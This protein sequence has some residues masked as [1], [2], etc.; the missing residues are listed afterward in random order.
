MLHPDPS[1]FHEGHYDRVVVD[2]CINDWQDQDG[3]SVVRIFS[4]GETAGGLAPEERV[5]LDALLDARYSLLRVDETWHGAGVRAHDAF[6]RAEVA[7]LDEDLADCEAGEWF[8]ARLVS[9]RG[10]WCMT[11]GAATV[12]GHVAGDKTPRE[13]AATLEGIEGRGAPASI[14]AIALA[15]FGLRLQAERMHARIAAEIEGWADAPPPAALAPRR[16]G[17]NQPCPC[18]SG[19][20]YKRCCGM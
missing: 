13:L 16:P 19:K 7:I 2:C 6:A 12:L 10:T 8:V 5:V 1:D 9:P 3:R 11:T 4:E 17:R 20:K 14:R 18:G 15:A